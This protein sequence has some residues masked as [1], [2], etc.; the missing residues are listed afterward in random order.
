MTNPAAGFIDF[1]SHLIPGV[2][3]GSATPEQSVE[4][5]RAFAAQGAATVLTTPHFDASLTKMPVAL[6]ARLG[7]F[8]AGWAQLVAAREAALAAEPGLVLPEIK[9]GVE[10]MLDDPD[11]DLSDDR[12]RLAGGAFVLCEFP[13]MQLPPNAEWAMHNLRQ[14][15]WRPVIAHPERYRN[16][17]TRLSVL[18]RCRAAGAH[19]Q[20]NAG[21]L[22]GQHGSRA[23]MVAFA[24]LQAGWVDYL[25]SDYHARGTP[26][27][28]RAVEALVQRGAAAQATRLTVENPARLLAGDGPLPV[29]PLDAQEAQSWWTRLLRKVAGT[30]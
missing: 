23:Q 18:S 6:A 14:K 11:P 28:A 15:G 21:S 1:H 29:Q 26:A 30:D 27:T 24:L 5:L 2:D 17:D 22:I 16:H 10:L 3:D 7:V 12:I 4:S 13:A 8:D 25:S 9:R 19:L 20:V